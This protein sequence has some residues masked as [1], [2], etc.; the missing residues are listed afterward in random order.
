VGEV[1]NKAYWLEMLNI[2]VGL[3][4]KML[5][6]KNQWCTNEQNGSAEQQG[7]TRIQGQPS[8]TTTKINK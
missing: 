8:T 5:R 1:A 7:S 4:W 6:K 3:G 2:Q